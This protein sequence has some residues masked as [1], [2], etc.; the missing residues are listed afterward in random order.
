MN[1]LYADQLRIDRHAGGVSQARTIMSIAAEEATAIVT[2]ETNFKIGTAED[3][4]KKENRMERMGLFFVEYLRVQKGMPDAV[5]RMGRVFELMGRGK[6]YEQAFAQAYG[7]SINQVISEV[8]A[9]FRRT[10]AHPT[11]RFKGTDFE[12]YLPK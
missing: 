10:E 2:G 8:V 3:K 7:I 4:I 1:L 6:T 11:E 12:K 9:F 5:S